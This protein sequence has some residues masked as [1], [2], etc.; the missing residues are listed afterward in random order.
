[1][2]SYI[3]MALLAA[4]VLL[5]LA[6]VRWTVLVIARSKP[7]SPPRQGGGQSA[8]P[9]EPEGPWSPRGPREE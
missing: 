7:P 3:D 9:E 6:A 2:K 8:E 5:A 4:V 1:M